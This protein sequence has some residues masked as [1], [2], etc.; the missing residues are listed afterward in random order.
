MRVIVFHDQVAPDAPPDLADNLVQARQVA[1]GL[2]EL[3]HGVKLLAFA[4]SP[5]ATAAELTGLRPDLVFNLVEAPLGQERLIQLAP[6]LLERLGLAFTGADTRAMILTSNKLTAKR[7]L[8]RAGLATPPWFAPDEKSRDPKGL[9]KGEC[10]VKAVWEHGSVGL[11]E[12]C[13]FQ[14]DSQECFERA[15]SAMKARI[16]GDCFAEQY[17][18]GREFNVSV[19][20][21]PHGPQVLPPA[22]IVFKG[23]GSRRP[24]LVGF[25]AK[26]E[27]SSYEY[28]NTS[29]SFDFSREDSP[30]LENLHKISLACWRR[31]GLR[32]WARVDFRVDRAGKPWVLEVN[33]NPCIASDAGFM[34]SAQ[35]AD[36]TRPQVLERIMGDAG[37]V[38]TEGKMRGNDK[39]PG[40]LAA[41]AC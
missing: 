8:S 7:E 17:I 12:N 6:L 15:V 29:R 38:P 4:D 37:R 34:A 14:G 36:L 25:K 10:L 35:K 18:D 1:Q 26:W 23:Y 31:F 9:P 2:E 41:Q 3:G 19:L 28:K 5:D 11:D 21:G 20:A 22:E 24:K 27:Q 32:G 13:L 39:Q 40:A 16:G 33:A 30:L